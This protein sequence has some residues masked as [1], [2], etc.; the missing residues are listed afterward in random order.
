MLGQAGSQLNEAD[1][2]K[3]YSDWLYTACC[4]SCS[5]LCIFSSTKSLNK[6]GGSLPDVLLT[7]ICLPQTHT[8]HCLFC[9]CR[10]FST[11][12]YTWSLALQVFTGNISCGGLVGGSGWVTGNPKLCIKHH[13]PSSIGS[14]PLSHRLSQWWSE[15]HLC[16]SQHNMLCPP[17]PLSE[18]AIW[19]TSVIPVQQALPPCPT[20]PAIIGTRVIPVQQALPPVPLSQWSEGHLCHTSSTDSV[21]CLSQQSEGHLSVP[22]QQILSPVWASNQRDTCQSQ[23]NRL[24]PQSEPAIR[25]TLISPSSTGSVSPCPTVWAS[26]GQR[27]TCG[28]PCGQL[29]LRY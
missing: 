10:R 9:S 19:G 2:Q 11:E 6:S 13:S 21:P 4:F 20:E 29:R 16:Q 23:F 26:D 1:K 27:D 28:Q 7:C 17:V 5:N 12:V 8:S 25:G 24:C 14:V 15:G 22:V 3:M 18:P